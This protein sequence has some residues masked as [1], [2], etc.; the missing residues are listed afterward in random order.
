M[1]LVSIVYCANSAIA[2]PPPPAP[3]PSPTPPP[4]FSPKQ[5]I[6]QERIAEQIKNKDFIVTEDNKIENYLAN[7]AEQFQIVR[8]ED[9][10]NKERLIDSTPINRI[11]GFPEI[12]RLKTHLTD[13]TLTIKI[14]NGTHNEIVALYDS[15]LTGGV[16]LPKIRIN[17]WVNGSPAIFLTQKSK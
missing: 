4:T 14:W 10:P 16:Q 2:Q 17:A 5:L 8:L 7:L 13:P 9:V 6:I 1:F 12:Y 11:Y 3:M 15:V